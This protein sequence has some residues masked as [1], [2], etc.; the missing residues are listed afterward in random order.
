M[1][2]RYTMTGMNKIDS[3]KIFLTIPMPI[4][5]KLKAETKD[6]SYI[7]VQ[8]C[9][10]NILRERYCVKA[11]QDNRGRPK[12]VKPKDVATKTHIFG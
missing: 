1:W 4:A 2:S 12:D 5:E 3:M 6:Y 8:D 7:S 10:V 9:L 11:D